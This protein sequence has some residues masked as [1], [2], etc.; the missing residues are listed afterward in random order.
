MSLA[1][2]T[3]LSALMAS[4]RM[5]EVAS[6]NIANAN[7]PGYSR[8]E[9]VLQARLPVKTT[10]GVMGT[11]V[12]IKQIMAMRDEF[13]NLRIAAQSTNLGKAEMQGKTLA[14]IETII[15]PGA[16]SGLSYAIEDFFVSVNELVSSAQS[17]VSR[18]AVRQSAASLCEVFRSTSDQLYQLRMHVKN[19]LDSSLDT[20]N[21]HLGEIARLNARI[22]SVSAGT[23]T[24][25][26]LIDQRNMEIEQ[27][28]K[29]LP[30]Q[31]AGS[32]G[33]VNILFEGR[34]VVS[35][36]DCMQFESDSTGGTLKVRVVGTVDSF[37]TAGGEVGAQAELYNVTIPKYIGQLDELARG[38][39]GEF[40]K[41][42]ATGVGL[43]NGYTF[44][45]SATQ[46]ADL[47]LNGVAG[48]EPLAQQNLA[49]PPVEGTLYVTVTN[50]A[51]GEL[52]RTALEID[53]AIDSIYDIKDKLASVSRLNAS[54]AAGY[55]TVTAWPGYRFD[56]SNKL[57]PDGGNLG[58]AEISVHGAYSG[59]NDRTFTFYPMSSGTVGE[60]EGLQVAVVDDQGRFLGLLN[61]GAGYNEGA[62]LE[63][64]GG[65]SVSFGA[66]ELHAAEAL[67]PAEP[68]A[69][70]DGA[71]LTL[72]IDGGPPVTVTFAAGDFADI[73]QA[74]AA[75]VAEVIGEAE[76][77]NAEVIDG[78]V[79]IRPIAG[80]P[81]RTLTLGGS[82][83][84][85]LGLGDPV[86]FGT[87]SQSL[88]VLAD[89]DTAGILAAL[90]LNTF[91]EGDSAGNASVSA[92]VESNLANIAAAKASPPGDNVNAV[93][94]ATL[95]QRQVMGGGT[96]T[97][98]DFYASVVGKVGVETSQAMRS[99]T[100]QTKLVESLQ[101]QRE[102][103]VGVSMEE[104]MA[105]LM[106][107]QQAYYAAARLIS[108]A[109]EMLKSLTNL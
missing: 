87:D 54:V 101:L 84:A 50:D 106:Q 99:T 16:D 82:A 48:D 96:Q 53:P 100:T 18:E 7:T 3:A 95:K 88:E 70:V 47:D 31:V 33:V 80:G 57:L 64:A 26:D 86:T 12:E 91:F 108:V 37:S 75:E 58:T 29:L 104:E 76:D 109:D 78:A 38:L 83:A 23:E 41:I 39:I 89:T 66:G 102:A 52:E 51:T 94:M 79:M 13:L 60:T 8:Q 28:S 27:L 14:E 19:G 68:F 67:T 24:A 4:Q 77:I 17:E 10:A 107:F 56:F 49:F 71:E 34:L 36:T 11:G 9:G 15:M 32:G 22:M 63:I 97:L 92:H 93:R 5:M 35:G 61:V 69:L 65:V 45:T 105:R 73:S 30:V 40:N 44:L 46:L 90:G 62:E 103:I 42:H 43:N 25:N 20:A 6:H 98:T 81:G 2:N 55:L 59:D 72:S 85:A 1:M 21:A 74:T